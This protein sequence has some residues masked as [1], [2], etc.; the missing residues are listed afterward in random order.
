[1]DKNSHKVIKR[2]ISAFLAL[3]ALVFGITWGKSGFCLGDR[4]LTSMGVPAWS[5]GTEGT[6]YAGV[7]ALILLFLAF[8]LFTATT[9]KKD[10]AL[11]FIAMGILGI[12]VLI[13]FLTALL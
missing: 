3:F 11:R 9:A 2:G 5:N 13:N 7:F 10:K 6:H 4:I 8:C 1:M 12:A